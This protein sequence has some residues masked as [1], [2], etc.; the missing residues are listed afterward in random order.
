MANNVSPSLQQIPTPPVNPAAQ[1]AATQQQMLPISQQ[2]YNEMIG[3]MNFMREQIE[4]ISLN[5]TSNPNVTFRNTM[6]AASTP[7][8]P[9]YDDDTNSSMISDGDRKS[10]GR[11]APLYNGTVKLQI[12]KPFEG[13][14]GTNSM[15]IENY[16]DRMDRFLRAAK[17]SGDDTDSLNLGLM[18]LDKVALSWYQS[19]EKNCVR[20]PDKFPV[21]RTWLELKEQIRVRFIPLATEGVIMSKLIKLKYSTSAEE[22]NHQF[23]SLSQLLPDAFEPMSAKWLVGLYL[24]GLKSAPADVISAAQNAVY[25]D[26]VDNVSSLQNIVV[27]QER[28]HRNSRSIKPAISSSFVPRKYGSSGGS[29]WRSPGGNNN[30]KSKYTTP[31]KAVLH[32]VDAVDAT[33]SVESGTVNDEGEVDHEIHIHDEPD[34][35]ENGG[36]DFDEAFLN[37]IK[38]YDKNKER[39]PKLTPEEYNRRRMNNTCFHC[40]QPGHQIKDCFSHKRA[41]EAGTVQFKPSSTAPKKF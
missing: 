2:T 38:S 13:L 16:F 5:V 3:A 12:P 40:N 36:T 23:N 37:A 9:R 14:P 34:A 10:T 27:L 1:N 11:P 29:N 31:V 7:H 35:D 19:H 6:N 20:N 28:I 33:D 26:K 17:I 30:W 24:E 25:A 15:E 18:S 39:N 8:H 21:I 22:Y 32:H 41:L 4:N